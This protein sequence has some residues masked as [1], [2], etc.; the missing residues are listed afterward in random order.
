MILY[1]VSGDSGS[2]WFGTQEAA[3]K[4]ARKL[5]TP[6]HEHDTPN[7][8][9]VERCHMVALTKANFLDILNTSGGSCVVESTQ[10]ALFQNG[11]QLQGVR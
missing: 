10:V 1:N 7:P 9:M 3:V 5:S 8:V 2:E 4:R 6:E 11:R